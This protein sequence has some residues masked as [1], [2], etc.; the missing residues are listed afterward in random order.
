MDGKQMRGILPILLPHECIEFR[1]SVQRTL[2]S[3]STGAFRPMYVR[4]NAVTKSF[5]FI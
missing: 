3:D 4:K 1:S 2:N 5:Q